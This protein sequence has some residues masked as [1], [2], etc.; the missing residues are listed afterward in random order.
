[1]AAHAGDEAADWC[2]LAEAAVALPPT[3]TLPRLRAEPKLPYIVDALRKLRAVY[4]PP[5]ASVAP[6]VDE[7]LQNRLDA[8]R[9]EP[10]E[11][12]YVLNWLGRLVESELAWIDDTPE[13]RAAVEDAAQILAGCT[14]ALE[15]GDLLRDFCFP[16]PDADVPPPF[17]GTPV[18]Q[19]HMRVRDASLPPSDQHSRQGAAEAAAAVGVQTYASSIIMSDLFVRRPGAW[20]TALE[21]GA[22]RRAH[23]RAMELGAGTGIVGMVVARALSEGV[24]PVDHATVGLTDYHAD[25][26]ANLQYNVKHYLGLASGRVTIECEP[27]DWRA[28]YDLV[29]PERASGA[30]VPC[31]LPPAHSY[32]LLLAADPVYDP[33]HATWLMGAIS[34]LLVQPDVDPEARAHILL[35]VRT[36]GRLAGLYKTV[37]EALATHVPQN[38][39]RL[40]VV[41]R[42]QWPRRHGL[43]RQD[44]SAYIWTALAWEALA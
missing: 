42:A 15:A 39:F 7:D 43:G 31:R 41:H 20:H 5:P 40:A 44:E 26:L 29:C 14:S 38:G 10:T 28:M 8:A 24:L 3:S 2:V 6:A 18:L 22:P 25:V 37:D 9:A 19:V 33:M 32:D 1:M 17:E 13:R 35:P 4:A 27:L 34:Y 16:T 11:R 12:A 23:F 30:A 36:A 21:P